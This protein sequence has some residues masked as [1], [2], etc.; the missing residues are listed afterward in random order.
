MRQPF[1][2][3]LA[4][5]VGSLF[6]AGAAGAQTLGTSSRQMSA[7][8]LKALVYYQGVNGQDLTFS[9]TGD[10]TCSGAPPSAATFPCSS[11]GKVSGEGDGGAMV[12]KL[13]YQPHESL[14]YYLSAGA[15][16]YSLRVASVTAVN[17]LTGDRPGYLY[18]AGFKAVL[19]PDTPVT[20]SV[21][22]DAGFGWQRYYFNEFQPDRSAGRGQIDQ[23]LDLWLTHIALQAGHLF[24]PD[25]WRFGIEPYGGLKW[26]RAQAWLKD[27]RGGGRVGGI[28]DTLS[29]FI[30]LQLPV[31]EK[32]GLFAEASFL[33]G[34]R[35]AAGLSVKFK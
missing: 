25:D 22:L 31:F 10:G 15:G 20:P 26:T 13:I 34:V 9:V 3:G 11:T 24:K 1:Q 2:R 17:S 12:L 23:K 33:G 21:A 7:G 14:Q 30:G 16:N 32:E 19:W 4:S 5:L 35:Y 6:L 29:P 18:S 27:L 28:E 8:S